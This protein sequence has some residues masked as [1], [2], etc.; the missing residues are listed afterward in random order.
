MRCEIALLLHFNILEYEADLA[1]L[2]QRQWKISEHLVARILFSLDVENHPILGNCC[3]LMIGWQ[4]DGF[5]L[6]L[7]IREH[8]DIYSV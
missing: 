3:W 6:P 8:F 5:D 1:S 2:P 4:A 7:F